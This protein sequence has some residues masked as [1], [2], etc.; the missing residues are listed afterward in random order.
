MPP[1]VPS[2]VKKERTPLRPPVVHNSKRSKGDFIGNSSSK[3]RSGKK[4]LR[5]SK[6]EVD[7]NA[8]RECHD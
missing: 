2:D 3:E 6:R 4:R 8:S 1:R 5:T 7:P